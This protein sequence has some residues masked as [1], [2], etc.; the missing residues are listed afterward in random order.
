MSDLGRSY[1]GLPD[2][3]LNFQYDPVTCAV[4]LGWPGAVIEE[5]NLKPAL[6]SEIL[7]FRSD[8]DG[9]PVSVVTDVDGPGFTEVW[10]SAVERTQR[11]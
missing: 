11:H 4:A 2:D 6:V 10:L 7:S 9:R 1:P 5:M 8:P 3:L